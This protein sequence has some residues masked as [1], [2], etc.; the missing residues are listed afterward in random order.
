MTEIVAHNMKRS[1]DLIVVNC[2]MRRIMLCIATERSSPLLQQKLCDHIKQFDW[3]S[4]SGGVTVI[5]QA[6]LFT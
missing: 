3:I 2:Q 1:N 6:R 5:H 4:S